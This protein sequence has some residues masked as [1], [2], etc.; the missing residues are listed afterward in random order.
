LL[1]G[2]LTIQTDGIT[3]FDDAGLLKTAS[4]TI[5]TIDYANGILTLNSGTMSNAKAVTYTP[6]AQILRAPQSSEIPVT[7][8]SRSQ[9]YVGTVNPVPQ[10]GTLSISYM[11]QGAGTCFPTVATV[12]SRAWTPATARAPSTGT[13]APSWSPWA[14]CPTS[15][16]RSC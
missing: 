5:G 10:P 12:R 6:A 9:S 13:P 8:E 14:H 11:A 1:A 3:I 16:V 4:G 15:A 7:P 2:S